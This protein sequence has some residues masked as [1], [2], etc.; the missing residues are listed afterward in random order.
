MDTMFYRKE[1]LLKKI[2]KLKEYRHDL[3]EIKDITFEEYIQNKHLR[4]SVERL[5]FLICENILDFFDHILSSRHEV[6][7]DS[8]EDI[9][10][11]SYKS[12][13]ID[14]SLY[15]DLQG[16]GGFRNVLAHGYLE[17]SDD[18]VFRNFQKMCLMIDGIIET[19]NTI[20]A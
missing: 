5:L 18:E 17:L 2:E 7:S 10:D 1:S 8:Y 6:I 20:I 19:L 16:L 15:A 13:L 4:Y 12:N 3:K 9:I 14:N 11:N